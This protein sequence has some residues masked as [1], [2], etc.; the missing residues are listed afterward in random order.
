MRALLDTNIVYDI[1]CKRPHDNEALTQLRIMHAFGD[2]ELWVSAKSFTDLFYL[3]RKDI[4]TEAAHDLLEDCL[5]WL[6]ACSIDEEDLKHAL[7]ARWHD[8]EDSLVNVCAEKT[9]SDY[10]VTRDEKGFRNSP[11]PHGSASAFMEFVFEKT[12]VRYAIS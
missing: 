1:L 6:H 2:V 7:E 3:M 4:G 5:T 12:R 10:L 11:I 8:F 9:G